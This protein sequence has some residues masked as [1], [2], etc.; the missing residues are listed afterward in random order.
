MQLKADFETGSVHT[1]T[2]VYLGD[3]IRHEDG[4]YYFWPRR[5]NGGCFSEGNLLELTALLRQINAEWDVQI[6]TDPIFNEDIKARQESKAGKPQCPDITPSAAADKG[7]AAVVDTP[8]R[9]ADNV[10]W[11][12][13]AGACAFTPEQA[14]ADALNSERRSDTI[15]FKSVLIIADYED[16]DLFIRSS[17]MSRADANWLVDRAKHNAFGKQMR[18]DD[19]TRGD[20]A[21]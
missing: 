10:R 4:S 18:L 12:W 19:S 20:D 1:E 15:P 14:L 16:G 11:A 2:D 17:R 8:G 13:T 6:Q 5:D 21:Q 3:V 9:V 7:T